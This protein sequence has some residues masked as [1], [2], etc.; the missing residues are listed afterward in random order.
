MIYFDYTIVR[1]QV[2]SEVR[3]FGQKIGC[4]RR[5]IN[6]RE[7][8]GGNQL[9]NSGMREVDSNTSRYSEFIYFREAHI[10]SYFYFDWL[11]TELDI[12]F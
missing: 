10:F 8:I 2:T 7:P 5:S 6:A 4:Y 3:D 11:W 1:Y 12:L 9:D